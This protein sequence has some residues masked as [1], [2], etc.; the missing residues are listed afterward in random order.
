MWLNE[1]RQRW[2]DRP[3]TTRRHRHTA[4]RPRVRL[5]VESLECRTLLSVGPVLT[6]LTLPADT[7]NIAYNQTITASEGT[8]TV[9]LAVSNV[10]GATLPGL[11]LPASGTGSLTISGTPKAIGTETFTVTATDT[12]TGD[13]TNANYS[14]TVNRA[15]SLSPGGTTTTYLP[16]DTVSVPYSQ[17]VITA[18]GGTG[19]VSL[20]VT[21][22]SNSSA[23]PGLNVPASG[24]GSLT[25]GGTPTGAG[26]ETFTVT[27][28]DSVG[29]QTSDKYSITVNPA[30]SL[31]PGPA[32]PALPADIV[33]VPYSQMIVASGGTGRVTLTVSAI[34]NQISGLTV[35]TSGTGDL[36]ISGMPTGA[37]MET[38]TVTAADSLG[39][40]ASATYSITVSPVAFTSPAASVA[41]LIG[42]IMWCNQNPGTN[43]IT[44]GTNSKRRIE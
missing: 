21:L 37:G 30:V 44:L 18:S 32:T 20:T 13:T 31:S 15:V 35:P 40:S 12:S 34:Q 1:L 39:A 8:D 19:T 36:A 33:N 6:P 27:A 25:I 10:Q 26:T 24:T 5:R 2:L 38:F 4:H 11:T 17:T 14:I 29:A 43:A 28:T 42:D 7:I 9:T 41:D 22:S 16:V 23:I 3:R